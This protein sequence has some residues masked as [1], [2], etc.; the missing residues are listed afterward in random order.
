MFIDSHSHLYVEEFDHDRDE[1]IQ[2]AKDVGIEAVLLPN[3]DVDSIMRLK[4][5]LD[6]YQGYC[7]GMMGLHPGSVKHDWQEQLQV[8]HHEL[9]Q[10]GYIA[11]GEIGM[12]LYWDQSFLQEQR[13]AFTTQLNWAKEM[14]LPVVIHARDAFQEIFDILDVEHEPEKLSG[15]FHCFTGN[16]SEAAKIL[17]YQTFSI[18]IG[19]VATYKKSALPEVLKQIPINKII[20]ETDSPYLPPVP[21]RGKRNE[22]S[23]LL[24]VAEKLADTYG[25]SAE[26]IGDITS[27]N[28]NNLF[29]YTK[30]K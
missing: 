23:W 11:I 5:S 9:V 25:L 10:G 7:F 13:A 18:G 15:V 14:N 27:R 21:Y 12:D 29:Q 19:G 16:E 22:S 8:I 30:K 2:R 24:Y 20:L 6:S 1:V 4:E 28:A 3:I 26:E 17:T